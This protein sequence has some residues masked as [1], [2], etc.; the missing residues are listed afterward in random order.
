[1]K[2]RRPSR[3][4]IRASNDRQQHFRVVSPIPTHWRPATCAELQCEPWRHG[5]KT[6]VPA[7]SVQD[8]YIRHHSGRQFEIVRSDDSANVA[9]Y[10]PPGQVCFGSHEGHIT[11][12]E[13]EPLFIH[14]ELQRK[15][16]MEPQAWIDKSQ[17]N[18]EQL[19]R[20]YG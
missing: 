20:T 4:A 13:R 9:F 6:I 1:M 10:F 11:K 14:S 8:D 5:W 7:G 16:V 19:K 15:Q 3:R 12:L 17:N 2:R 18:L